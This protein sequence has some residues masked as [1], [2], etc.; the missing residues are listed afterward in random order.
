MTGRIVQGRFEILDEVGRGGMGIVYRARQLTLDRIVALKMLSANLVDDKEFRERFCQE[1][2]IIAR[3]AH[4]NVIQVYD[5]Y[6]VEGEEG[7]FYIVMEYIDGSPLRD[8][9]REAKGR[10]PVDRAA[11][12]AEQI[13]AGLGYAH[14]QGIIHRD[15][16]PDNIMML[17]GDRVKITDFGI[18]RL[19]GS[20][21]QT[22]TGV[23]MGTPQFMSPEQAAGKS[24][25]ARSDLYSLAVVL[26]TMVTGE[27]PFSGDSP[28]AIALKQIQETPRR[29]S[30]VNA[31]VP[32]ALDTIILKG[33]AK[34]ISERYQ[35]AEA[36]GEALRHFR[37]S[38][39]VVASADGDDTHVSP[40]IGPTPISKMPWDE[41]L[42]SG[43]AVMESPPGET[44]ETT[45]PP[46]QRR[47][48]WPWIVAFVP[49]ALALAIVIILAIHSSNRIT[50]RDIQN[51]PLRDL[52][53]R[54]MALPPDELGTLIRKHEDVLFQRV[55]KEVRSGQ[56]RMIWFWVYQAILP[57]LGEDL[58]DRWKILLGSSRRRRS[59]VT[60]EQV[61]VQLDRLAQ[62]APPDP[63]RARSEFTSATAILNN[64]DSVADPT[65]RPALALKALTGLVDS[66][67]Y[68]RANWQYSWKLADR[69]LAILVDLDRYR[70]LSL[71][72]RG[73]IITEVRRLIYLA[74]R[75]CP[76]EDREKVHQLEQQLNWVETGLGIRPPSG[77]G[78]IRRRGDPG[79]GQ[80]NRG[81][82][83]PP[84]RRGPGGGP[85]G[86]EK[87]PPAAPR[88]SRSDA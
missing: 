51:M 61:Q 22:Q 47:I 29:P 12:I 46:Q 79:P 14:N 30:E 31:A 8:V 54:L 13:A 42:P 44:P 11:S 86:S 18:A 41:S 68:D 55:E 58:P 60:I 20:S 4:P 36:F 21:V 2:K 59:G 81:T 48:N 85:P 1:A 62:R 6:D 77:R 3:L 34:Q 39:E 24:V 9:L 27:L 37:A 69:L 72:L 65:S 64:L 78:G 45:S 82:G 49:G 25:D 19:R 7:G 52:F 35:S 28:V 57:N 67:R 38:G 84:S 83:N 70:S 16:K 56:S 50:T 73:Q 66:V 76:R 40:P 63:D 15:I 71:P 88:A 10:L 53:P 5:I 17:P 33:M 26:Y 23:S 75:N 80:D 87:R 74:R 43:A 32:P